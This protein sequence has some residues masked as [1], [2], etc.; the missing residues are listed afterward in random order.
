MI[1]KQERKQIGSHAVTSSCKTCTRRSCDIRLLLTSSPHDQKIMICSF[2]YGANSVFLYSLDCKGLKVY[3]Q[4][5]LENKKIALF[6]CISDIKR[7][8]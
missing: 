4:R 2:T 5:I 6:V 7:R 1:Q 8:G 3:I